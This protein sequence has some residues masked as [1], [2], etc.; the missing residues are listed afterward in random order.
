[1]DKCIRNFILVALALDIIV[2]VIIGQYLPLSNATV[3]IGLWAVLVTGV[4]ALTILQVASHVVFKEWI[5]EYELWPIL[6]VSWGIMM[7]V[8]GSV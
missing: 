2:G 7:M 4:I 8:A 6:V 1:V 5:D 3:K